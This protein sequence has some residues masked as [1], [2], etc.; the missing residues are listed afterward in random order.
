[1]AWKNI[2]PHVI[3]QEESGNTYVSS[4]LKRV[5]EF[6]GV[7]ERDHYSYYVSGGGGNQGLRNNVGAGRVSFRK[8]FKGAN[9]FGILRG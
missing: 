1:M 4:T 5:E 8:L 2:V 9:K 7:C 6:E 3:A